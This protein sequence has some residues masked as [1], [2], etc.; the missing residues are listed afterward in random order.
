MQKNSNLEAKSRKATDFVPHLLLGPREQILLDLF[1]I[2]AAANLKKLFFNEQELGNF[3]PTRQKF[4]KMQKNNSNLEAKSGE[5][6]NSVPHPLLGPREQILVDLFLFGIR[7]DV[8]VLLND[9]ESTAEALPL[10]AVEAETDDP[11]AGAVFPHFPPSEMG[12]SVRCV[13]RYGDGSRVTPF[14]TA[15]NE[16]KFVF[17][18]WGERKNRIE[19]IQQNFFFLQKNERSRPPPRTCQYRPERTSRRSGANRSFRGR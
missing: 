3:L 11:V 13:V 5:S 9:R 15:K 6:T 14:I 19:K 18:L 4:S 10:V 17:E 1:G 8:L 2:I 7:V 16:K 12:D